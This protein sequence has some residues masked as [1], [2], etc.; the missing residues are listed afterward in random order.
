MLA[1]DVID[2]VEGGSSNVRDLGAIDETLRLAGDRVR[3][4]A[5]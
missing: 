4:D 2:R 1:V 5:R 3:H